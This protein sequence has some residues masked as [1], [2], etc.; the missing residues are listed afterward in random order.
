MVYGIQQDHAAM[1]YLDTQLP[2]FEID[3]ID[4][5]NFH[6]AEVRRTRVVGGEVDLLVTKVEASVSVT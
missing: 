3:P 5:G 2:F 6:F 1:H 4:V